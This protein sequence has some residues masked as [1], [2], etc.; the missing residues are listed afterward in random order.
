MAT[1]P[2]GRMDQKAI[3]LPPHRREDCRHAVKGRR[4]IAGDTSSTPRGV[5]ALIL[6]SPNV[7]ARIVDEDID[8]AMLRRIL[9]TMFS[10]DFGSLKSPGAA[11]AAPPASRIRPRTDSSGASRRPVKTTVAPADAGVCAAASPIPEPAPVIQATLPG[12]AF[13]IA[14]RSLVGLHKRTTCFTSETLCQ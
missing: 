8:A 2:G 4:Q 11:L 1:Q 10:A 9:A 13:M 7:D 14:P 6:R 5:K 12:N 3:L